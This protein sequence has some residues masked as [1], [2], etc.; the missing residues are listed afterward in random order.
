[1]TMRLNTVRKY[2]QSRNANGALFGKVSNIYWLFEGNIDP[3][4]DLFS[5][6]GSFFILILSDRVLIICPTTI[7][8][9]LKEEVFTGFDFEYLE[10]PWYGDPLPL[11][12]K[13]GHK[14]GTIVTDLPELRGVKGYI[15]VDDSFYSEKMVLSERE[16]TR[17]RAVG[18]LSE[19]MLY[20]FSPELSPGLTEIEIEKVLRALLN[21]MGLEVPFI[22]VCSDERI[23]SYSQSHSTEKRVKRY[24]RISLTTQKQGLRV[25]LTRFFYFGTIPSELITVHEK[26]CALY[27]HL[28]FD[29][30]NSETMEEVYNKIHQAY[31]VLG[32]KREKQ[33]LYVGGHT[34]YV[35]RSFL[36]YTRNVKIRPCTAYAYGID[37]ESARSEDTFLIKNDGNAEFLT[38][39][40]DFP[41]IVVKVENLKVFRPWIMEL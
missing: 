22:G 27:A 10:Y 17:L 11:L 34:G 37:Y 36:V 29:T 23:T 15:G 41:K 3:R 39:G 16:L 4:M 33:E 35:D 24:L 5:D 40:E 7:Y 20:E 8:R 31:S 1:M 25:S 9:R 32:L 26:A 19:S 14:F 18:K 28:A 38:L 2:Y 13:L 12:E 21:E 30:L 6:R